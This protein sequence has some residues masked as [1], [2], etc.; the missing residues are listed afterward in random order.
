MKTHDLKTDSEVFDA[1]FNGFKRFEIRKNDRDFHVGDMLRLR[2]TRHSGLEMLNGAPL[3]YT[4]RESAHHVIYI[5]HGPIY[6]L[7]NGWVIMSIV[8]SFTLIAVMLFVVR[9]SIL[10]GS[11]RG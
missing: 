6:G 8:K 7:K 2:E 4:Q 3:E 1:V 5:L 10:C 9:L 11:P